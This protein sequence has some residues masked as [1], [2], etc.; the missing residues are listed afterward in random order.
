VI[1]IAFFGFCANEPDCRT[2][3]AGKPWVRLRVGVGQGDDIQWVSVACFGKSADLAGALHKG[4]RVY[5][6]GRAPMVL[7]ATASTC[8]LCGWCAHI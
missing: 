4:D 3:Q 8:V 2:S 6:E 1:D 7:S 5:V